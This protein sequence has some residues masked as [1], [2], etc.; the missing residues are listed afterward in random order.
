M[1]IFTTFLLLFCSNLTYSQ[2]IPFKI[3]GKF[4]S[5]KIE[6]LEVLRNPDLKVDT[7]IKREHD[8]EIIGKLSYPD[9]IEVVIN[10][11][12]SAYGMFIDEKPLKILYDV[13]PDITTKNHPMVVYPKK[14]SGNIVSKKQSTLTQYFRKSKFSENYN[15]KKF[16]KISKKVE[17]YVNK[18]PDSYSSL[19]VIGGNLDELSNDK[20][21]HLMEKLPPEIQKTSLSPWIY[22]KLLIRQHNYI[23][24]EVLNFNFEDSLGFKHSIIDTTKEFT[25]LQFWDSNCGPC[26]MVNR[27]LAGNLSKYDLNKVAFISV[28]L[29]HEK[30]EWLKAI[31]KDKVTWLQLIENQSFES[32]I[33]KYFKFDSI[34]FDLLINK[35]L[36][37]VSLGFDKSLRV[38]EKYKK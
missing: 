36:R 30:E 24:K 13:M 3:Y 28:S 31:K 22:G 29:D 2:Q 25:L 12:R 7:I 20:L 32:E 18:F 26:R 37:I 16:K 33:V 5:E 11:Y 38:L 6:Y 10:N 17:N 27:E 4:P 14:I 23:G 1:K 15:D 9:V 34:P 19:W 21:L 8:F 35:N